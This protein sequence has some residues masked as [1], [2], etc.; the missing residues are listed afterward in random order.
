MAETRPLMAADPIFRAP[1]PEMVSES[2]FA[3]CAGDAETQIRN[4]SSG[5]TRYFMQRME[6]RISKHSFLAELGSQRFAT[7]PT[8]I[9]RIG[10]EEINCRP[11]K[12]WPEVWRRERKSV[13]HPWAHS[14]R[15]FRH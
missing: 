14:A 4:P 5:V 11:E 10:N 7:R 3:S 2:N 6:V 13:H 9:W 1:R 8:A 15:P 12:H